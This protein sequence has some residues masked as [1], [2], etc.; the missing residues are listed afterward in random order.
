MK[1]RGLNNET[2]GDAA[3]TVSNEGLDSIGVEHKSQKRR[4][5][6]DWCSNLRMH[7]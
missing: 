2:Y 6:E 4:L 3:H 7:I 5:H 1:V